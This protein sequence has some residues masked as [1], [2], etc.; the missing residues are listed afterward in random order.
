MKG[1]HPV[2]LLCALLDVAPSGYYRWR[3]G[4]PSQRQREDAA[5]AAQIVVAHEASRGTYGVPRILDDLR[6]VG[7]RTSKRRC[8]RLMRAA[9]LRGRKKHARQPQTTDSRHAQPVAPNL[10][11]ERPA[12]T[13]PNQC[14]LTDITYLK[15]AEG[16]LYLAAIL[17]LWSRKIVGWACAPTLHTS[18]VLAA[19]T[20]ALQ[21]RQPTAGLLHHSDRGSQYVDG[22]YID[23]LHA[24][25]IERSMSRAGNC[26]D[27]AAMESF[28]S[29]LKT[30][31]GL[32]E[33]IPDSR[34]H[35]ELAVFDYIETF[36]NPTRRHSSLGNIS[37]VVFEK[38]NTLNKN[39]AA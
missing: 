39:K 25:G 30:D 35:T 38:Q 9:G 1:E 36:Y 37:P 8:G 27:N 26:Y 14:W 23:A 33:A 19:L 6:D 31:T 17:D 32:D 11:A 16:W 24:A 3:R 4:D 28:W 22:D 15:T 18:L 2:Q 29:T 7:T 12:P 13:G 10:I 21:R 5:I 20:N 34:R